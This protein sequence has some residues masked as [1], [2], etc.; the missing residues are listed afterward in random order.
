MN[1]SKENARKALAALDKLNCGV[2]EDIDSANKR[3]LE[4]FLKACEKKLPSE[5]AYKAEKQ[6][7]KVSK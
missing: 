1:A 6:R 2:D 3:F 5:T 7:N 4:Q